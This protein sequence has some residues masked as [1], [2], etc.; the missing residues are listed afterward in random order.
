MLY[1][2]LT[3]ES[4]ITVHCQMNR[5]VDCK[6]G[7]GPGVAHWASSMLGGLTEN[8]G[9]VLC[10]DIDSEEEDNYIWPSQLGL[11][12]VHLVVPEILWKCP[13]RNPHQ[14]AKALMQLQLSAASA[15]NALLVNFDRSSA[16]V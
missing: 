10:T 7:M 5:Q 4:M 9:N 2:L 15:A 12:C 13:L 3:Q 14:P 6:Q 8:V 16:Q 11:G 1:Q